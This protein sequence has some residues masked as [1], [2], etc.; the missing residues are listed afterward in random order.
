MRTQWRRSGRTNYG[1][2]LALLSVFYEVILLDLGTGVTSPLARFAIDR[3]N[4]MLLVST[5][6][7]ITSTVVLAALELRPDLRKAQ[8]PARVPERSGHSATNSANS[9]SRKRRICSA[10]FRWS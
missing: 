4:Q 5:P 1:Q 10:F 3:A 9:R 7:W 8:L 6:E 2:L